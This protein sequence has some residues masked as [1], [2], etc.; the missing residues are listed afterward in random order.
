M[1]VQ[2]VVTVKVT[3]LVPDGN[4]RIV[5]RPYQSQYTHEE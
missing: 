3:A 1:Q 5:G 2:T 4:S